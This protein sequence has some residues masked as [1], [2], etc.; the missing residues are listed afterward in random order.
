MVEVT[1]TDR[2]A[3]NAEQFEKA[4]LAN[5]LSDYGCSGRAV[6]AFP[7]NGNCDCFNRT[8][9]AHRLAAI[10]A[11]LDD[12]AEPSEGMVRACATMMDSPSVFMGGPSRQNTRLA[13]KVIAAMLAQYRKETLPPLPGDGI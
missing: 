4:F 3:Q 12:M 9:A 6:C 10:A 2:D 13:P 7:T 8:L 5:Q 1:Q 11:V